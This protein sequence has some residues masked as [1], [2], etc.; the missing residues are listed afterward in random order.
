[1]VARVRVS[2]EFSVLCS[3][4]LAETPLAIEGEMRYLFTLRRAPDEDDDGGEPDGSAEAIEIDAFRGELDMAPYAWETLLLALPERVLCRE[5]CKGLCP[6]CGRNLN[7]GDCGCR[8]DG[9]DP[10]LAVL[11]ELL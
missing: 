10:R 4:C 5:D 3:R 8:D 6:V 11:R 2:G 1:M 9:G 7:E